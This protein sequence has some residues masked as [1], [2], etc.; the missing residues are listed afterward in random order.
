MVELQCA[1][2]GEFFERR[3][4]DVDNS[5]RRG[6]KNLCCSRSCGM[7]IRNKVNPPPGGWPPGACSN[8]RDQFTGLRW[9]MSRVK[10]REPES[11]LTLQ[12]LKDQWDR[13]DGRCVYTGWKLELPAYH[14]ERAETK[15]RQ[16]RFTR[17]LRRASLD[18]IDSSKGYE[19]G[20]I[21]FVCLMANIAKSDYSSEDLVRFCQA[22]AWNS[23]V[24]SCNR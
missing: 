3:K 11:V 5:I 18:R 2:C 6:F 14:L 23:V 12:D 22:V 15:G 17:N 8:R 7:R 13:Q 1:A 21:Q 24:T 9:F 4:A 10:R 19:R 16:R 20:N